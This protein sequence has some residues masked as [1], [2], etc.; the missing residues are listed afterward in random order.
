MID[1]LWGR[2]GS[3]AGFV[4][5]LVLVSGGL[6]GVTRAAL[7]V[8]QEQLVQKARADRSDNLR[9]ALW[10]LDSRISTILAR[11]D[12]R[13]FNHFTA[14]FAPPA[15]YDASGTPWPSGSVLEPSPQLNAEL[16]SWMLLHF[17][18]DA[19][20]WESP[21][22]LSSGLRR[23]LGRATGKTQ[24]LNATPKRT[25]LLA[26]LGK[27]L[28]VETLLSHAR[29]NTRPADVSD[30]T[31]LARMGNTL[32]MVG[33]DVY[34]NNNEGGQ[35]WQEFAQ[36]AGNQSKLVNNYNSISPERVNKEVALLN[37]CRNGEEWLIQ[38]PLTSPPRSMSR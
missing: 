33:N 17:Q 26:E 38:T 6:A 27:S 13:P 11:E 36:R 10:R 16:P 25:R 14:V 19:R 31:L 28:P 30:R 37:S 32:E 18:T 5:V 1:V 9:L 12:S 15:A 8:E 4:V 20:G 3:V 29:R 24:P 22:V 23:W 35:G 7:R 34:R 2:R 21:Q